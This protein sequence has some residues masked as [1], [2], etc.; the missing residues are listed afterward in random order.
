VWFE[1]VGLVAIEPLVEARPDARHESQPT[2]RKFSFHSDDRDCHKRSDR[3][4]HRTSFESIRASTGRRSVAMHDAGRAHATACRRSRSAL[5]RVRWRT[6]DS[7]RHVRAVPRSHRSRPRLR[8][9]AGCD[10]L[11]RH[12]DVVA[13]A[14]GRVLVD[15]AAAARARVIIVNAEPTP[16]DHLAAEVIRDPISQAVP[17]LIRRPAERRTLARASSSR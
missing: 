15:V 3:I 4:V 8:G 6:E 11:R 10:G 7:D 12:R 9:S 2:T 16:Y 17:D 1:F 5:P 14:A 13:G